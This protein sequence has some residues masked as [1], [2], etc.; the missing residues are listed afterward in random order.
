[1]KQ[2]N[3]GS[4]KGLSA[5]RALWIENQKISF[6][7]DAPLP[8]PDE[9][10][11]LV[12]IRLAG[13]CSTDLALLEGYYPFSGIPG[14]EF[15][16]EVIEPAPDGEGNDLVG[17]RV[18]GEI[19]IACGKCDTCRSGMPGHCEERQVLGIL[20]RNGVFAEYIALPVKNLHEVPSS[21]DDES[22]VFTEPL[23]AAL[24]IQEQV[25]ISSDDRVLVI[26]AGRLGLLAALSL[27]LRDCR[28]KVVVRHPIQVEILER[29][30]V[31]SIREEDIQSGE[32]DL[33][34]E[35]TGSPGGLSLAS[36]AVRPRG[37]IVLKSTFAGSSE[38]NLSPLVVNEVTLVGSRCGPFDKALAM[39]ASGRLDLNAMIA[40][41][42]ALENG[43][44]A[45]EHAAQ[46]GVLKVLLSPA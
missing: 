12:R 42:Y 1:L 38:V 32:A 23:A 10:E 25:S 7:E 39:L 24:Q 15:I 16:G 9:G 28:L 27:A 29:Y 4:K 26:G 34:I 46:P 18:V 17:K 45:F 30:G 35:A 2:N 22:A 8:A 5:M 37:T 20:D 43:V 19:T 40:G 6:R 14:H 21:L 41:R 44:E 3:R 33:V 31:V 36:K 13:I 11:A